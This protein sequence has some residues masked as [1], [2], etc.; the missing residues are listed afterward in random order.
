VPQCLRCK[1][2]Q[3]MYSKRRNKAV[4][5]CTLLG[6]AADDDPNCAQFVEYDKY[7]RRL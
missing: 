2:M 6:T 4:R 7:D 1:Y 5:Y 3:I